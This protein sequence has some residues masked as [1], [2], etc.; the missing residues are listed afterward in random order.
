[1]KVLRVLYVLRPSGVEANLRASAERWRANGIDI[2]I[3]AT[4]PEVG[5]FAPALRAVGYRIEHLPQEPVAAFAKRYLALLRRN[6]YD[7]V[8]VQA[9]QGNIATV[10]IARLATSRVVRSCHNSFNFRGPLRVERTLQRRLLRALGIVHVSV[11]AS[12]ARSE[13]FNFRNPTLRVPNAF[14]DQ[15]FRP[16]T[17]GERAAARAA[18]GV[19]DDD[20]VVVSVGN[21]SRIKNHS[22]VIEA[23]PP[24]SGQDKHVLYLH[25]GAEEDGAPERQLAERLGA[26]GH[27]RFLGQRDD[28]DRLLHAADCYVMP[29]LQEGLS[30]AAL[31][32]LA[33]GVPVALADVP[34]LR[35]LRDEV[36]GI[37]WMT[38]DSAGV[39]R[40]ITSL[41]AL[42][43]EERVRTTQSTVARTHAQFAMDRHVRRYVDLYEGRLHAAT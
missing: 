28:V 16:P 13:W 41:R 35:D 22:A 18:V 39:E 29:S 40:A 19:G 32:A 30:N 17:P 3:L 36:P 8:H 20:F 6:R 31:E 1:M 27:V 2:D 15:R 14:D 34:G 24:L 11:S 37:H 5:P 9:E 38:P 26:A 4:G 43:G 42:P 25:V 7:L 21:C 10:G 23:L 12:V 33:S